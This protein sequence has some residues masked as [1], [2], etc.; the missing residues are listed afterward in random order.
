MHLSGIDAPELK[1]PFGRRS[2]QSLYALCF[3]K[4]ARIKVI[5]KD[6]YGR[7]VARVICEDKDVGWVRAKPV[8]SIAHPVLD[9]CWV[10]GFALTQP[11]L[12]AP[13]AAVEVARASFA[14]G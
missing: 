8:T 6:R 11:T 1:Q 3:R 5:E 13:H 14:A 2:R 4:L 9:S 10:T 12:I 7:S